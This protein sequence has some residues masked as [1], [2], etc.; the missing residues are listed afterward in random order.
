MA[1]WRAD[2]VRLFIV[3]IEVIRCIELQVSTTSPVEALLHS[4]VVLPCTFSHGSSPLRLD[5]LAV[6]WK[7][8]DTVVASY[9]LKDDLSTPRARLSDAELRHGNAS[10]LLS[11]VTIADQGL[12]ECS[13]IYPP[14]QSNGIVELK[15][16]NPPKISIKSRLVTPNTTNTLQCTCSDF[17]PGTIKIS[18]QRAEEVIRAPREERAEPNENRTFTATSYLLFTPSSKD[19]NV[20]FSCVAHH[21]AMKQPERADFQL[22]FRRR[23]QIRITPSI[24]TPD[25]EQ[26]LTCDVDGFYPE[27]I[28][29]SWVVKGEEI[30]SSKV[31]RKADGNYRMAEHYILTP[32]ETDAGQVLSCKIWQEGF[33]YPL[34]EEFTVRL[35]DKSSFQPALIGAMSAVIILA[36]ASGIGYLI[37]RTVQKQKLIV[38]DI[39]VPTKI[40]VGKKVCLTCSIEGSDLKGVTVKWLVNDNLISDKLLCDTQD[41]F[42]LSLLSDNDPQYWIELRKIPSH[43]RKQVLSF[44]HFVVS[45]Q[46]HKGAEFKCQVSQEGKITCIVRKTTIAHLTDSTDC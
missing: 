37:W 14:D 5:L 7:W 6:I 44:L 16:M 21:V 17:Y 2:S 35:E 31:R 9:G 3:L 25:K 42:N 30:S 11:N 28:A 29:V 18:W 8:G 36:L 23:P 1:T 32:G 46:E 12:Y 15:A 19:A 45:L 43:G 4:D 27:G 10:L 41:D 24:L 33:E 13:I 22:E 39:I 26:T 38:S 40:K 34:I 20:T